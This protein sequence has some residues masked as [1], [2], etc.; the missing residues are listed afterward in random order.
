[1]VTTEEILGDSPFEVLSQD[2]GESIVLKNGNVTV[3][4]NPSEF[5]HSGED[6]IAIPILVVIAEEG[7]Q[8]QMTLAC[9]A[10][11]SSH[12]TEE[13]DDEQEKGELEIEDIIIESIQEDAK[14]ATIT[15]Y[16][17]KIGELEE[18]LKAS[19]FEYLQQRGIDEEFAGKLAYIAE[20][21]EEKKYEKWVRDV[22]DFVQKEEAA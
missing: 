17:P 1:M 3:E 10:R 15:P 14:D 20:V 7:S 4:L 16:S 19:L 12:D 6:E 5:E 2:S 21:K 18:G 8:Q 11:G 9:I 13:E 22:L